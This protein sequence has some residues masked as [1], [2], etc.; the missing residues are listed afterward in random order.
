MSDADFVV[1]V[2]GCVATVV[3]ERGGA[4]KRIESE[5]VEGVV[6]VVLCVVEARVGRGDVKKNSV[7][8][9]LVV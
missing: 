7:V 2:S 8:V 1:A 4:V 3:S 6:D 9:E 5:S